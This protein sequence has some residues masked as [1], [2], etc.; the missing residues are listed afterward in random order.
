M[1]RLVL[2]TKLLRWFILVF[3]R[4]FD[5]TN[6]IHRVLYLSYVS[7]AQWHT[8][9][10]LSSLSSPLSLKFCRCVSLNFNLWTLKVVW[11][12]NSPTT[13][14]SLGLL[15]IWR[16][17]FLLG[18]GSF[19]SV[20]DWRQPRQAFNLFRCSCLKWLKWLLCPQQMEY[21]RDDQKG[22]Y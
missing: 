13:S 1:P 21:Q 22:I 11:P 6:I 14:L 9:C 5:F 12:V 8:I 3:S 19:F 4:S 7:A 10:T 2:A 18:I 15:I 16:P 17:F 20:L